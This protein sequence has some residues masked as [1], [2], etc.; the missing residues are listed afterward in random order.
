VLRAQTTL[1]SRSAHLPFLSS[2]ILFLMAV[3]ILLLARSTTPLDCEWYTEVK[4]SLVLME[5]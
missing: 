2:R 3:K 5:R 1:G 4:E